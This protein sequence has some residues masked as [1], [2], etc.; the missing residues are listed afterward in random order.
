MLNGRVLQCTCIAGYGT[1]SQLS[2]LVVGRSCD[3][4]VGKSCACGDWAS[5]LLTPARGE[6]RKVVHLAPAF[7]VLDGWTT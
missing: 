1:A 5:W 6:G 7:S 2:R 3:C 4:T